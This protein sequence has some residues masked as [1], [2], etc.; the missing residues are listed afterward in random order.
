M[1]KDLKEV[2]DQELLAKRK[3]AKS[4]VLYHAFFIGLLIGIVVFSILKNGF[5]FF[6]LIP[7]FIAYK[8]SKKKDNSKAIEEE[9]K[10][11]GLK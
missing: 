2:S 1:E 8:F 3:T 4:D 6:I 5:G 9:I 7:L 10:S 11:R